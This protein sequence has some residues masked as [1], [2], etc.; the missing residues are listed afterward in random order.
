[1]D[2]K[3]KY[4]LSDGLLADEGAQESIVNEIQSR[5]EFAFPK[6]YI[7]F[8][9]E[10]NGFEGEIGENSWLDLFAFEELEIHNNDYYELLME[11]IPEYYLIGKDS[12]DTGFAFHKEKHTFHSF[13]LMSNFKTDPVEFCGDSFLEFIEY[14]YNKG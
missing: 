1:M 10:V 11:E 3:L 2:N 8:M 12:A 5:S 13:G 7:E 6:D 14:L 4:F 9:K